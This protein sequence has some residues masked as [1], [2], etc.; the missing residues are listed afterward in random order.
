MESHSGLIELSRPYDSTRGNSVLLLVFFRRHLWC[1]SDRDIGGMV[2]VAALDIPMVQALV[3]L[4][5]GLLNI[6]R[7][8]E[9]T[10]HLCRPDVSSTMQQCVHLLSILS[11]VPDHAGVR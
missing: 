7:S 2:Q 4:S 8:A 9:K 11:A 6:Y 1:I 5:S 3:S 10:Y